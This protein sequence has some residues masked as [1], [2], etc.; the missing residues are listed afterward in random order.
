MKAHHLQ[1]INAGIA[2]VALFA[3]LGCAGDIDYT[4]QCIL[5]MSCEEYDTIKASLTR[6]QGQQ[7]SQRDIARWWAEHHKD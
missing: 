7:P 3:I 2:I 4:E 6:Q 1:F 5:N